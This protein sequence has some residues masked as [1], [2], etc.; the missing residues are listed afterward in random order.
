MR[1]CVRVCVSVRA[2]S[3]A[4][5]GCRARHSLCPSRVG[6]ALA[7]AKA[8]MKRLLPLALLLASSA[9]AQPLGSEFRVNSYTTNNQQQSAV[10]ADASGGFLVVWAGTPAST[11]FIYGQRYS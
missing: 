5:A 9:L 6:A 3:S 1:V 10:A 11:S 2:I 8:S 4:A 7:P